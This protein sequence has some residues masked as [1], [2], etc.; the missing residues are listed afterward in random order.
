MPSWERIIQLE[1][2]VEELEEELKQQ[3]A[4]RT[5]AVDAHRK[6]ITYYDGRRLTDRASDAYL[7]NARILRR[8]E[9]VKVS[10]GLRAGTSSKRCSPEVNP[11]CVAARR[12]SAHDFSSTSSVRREDLR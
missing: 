12:R 5:K 2:R 8:R 4:A 1:A 3:K 10:A 9:H 6:L 7:P 11:R